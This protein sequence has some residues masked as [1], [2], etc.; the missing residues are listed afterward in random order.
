VVAQSPAP[1]KVVV[2]G[3]RIRMTLAPAG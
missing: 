3:T 1:G 2:R